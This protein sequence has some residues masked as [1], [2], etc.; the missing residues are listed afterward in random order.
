MNTSVGLG[1]KPRPAAMLSLLCIRSFRC[2]IS[3]SGVIVRTGGGSAIEAVMRSA[4]GK[5]GA[6]RVDCGA[7]N[8]CTTKIFPPVN[9]LF[10]SAKK[11]VAN[12]AKEHAPQETSHRPRACCYKERT[13]AK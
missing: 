6:D 12:K 2:R 11:K 13:R 10:F 8:F 3:S 9:F 5:N 4:Q 7:L 1:V